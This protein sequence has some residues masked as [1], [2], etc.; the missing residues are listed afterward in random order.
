MGK[1]LR[2]YMYVH[3]TPCCSSA[4]EYSVTHATPTCS[5]NH[6]GLV[7]RRALDMSLCLGIVLVVVVRRVLYG[8]T[9]VIDRKRP[10]E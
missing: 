10:S 5:V 3:L 2:L 4:V 7:E 6:I 8:A 9:H 1:N